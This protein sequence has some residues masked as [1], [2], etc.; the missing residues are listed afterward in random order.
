MRV[1]ELLSDEE[2]GPINPSRL[3]HRESRPREV[4]CRSLVNRIMRGEE[5]AEYLVEVPD[6]HA[7]IVAQSMDCHLRMLKHKLLRLTR[8]LHFWLGAMS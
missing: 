7:G 4:S 2:A 3:M 6:R 1:S 8:C 5:P